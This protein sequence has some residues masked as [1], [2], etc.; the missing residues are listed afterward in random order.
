[1]NLSYFVKIVRIRIMHADL[2]PGRLQ[3]CGSG[4]ETPIV[5]DRYRYIFKRV[6]GAGLF[7][8]GAGGKTTPKFEILAKRFLNKIPSIDIEEPEKL[9]KTL[10]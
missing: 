9:K 8:G 6:A 4:S 7:P 2:D 10:A 1:M 5:T 3:L